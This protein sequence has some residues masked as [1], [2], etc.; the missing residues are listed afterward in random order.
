MGRRAVAGRAGGGCAGGGWAGWVD[1]LLSGGMW[2]AGAKEG[3]WRQDLAYR[4]HCCTPSATY[5]ACRSTPRG[6]AALRQMGRSC[7]CPAATP[8]PKQH[9]LEGE[10]Q[11]GKAV[12]GRTCTKQ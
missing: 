9:S 7:W 12:Q 2:A 6:L 11:Q 1:C 10:G 8:S 5:S 4:A 3:E